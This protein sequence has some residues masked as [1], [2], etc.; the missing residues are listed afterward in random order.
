MDEETIARLVAEAQGGDSEAFGGIFD[1][2][3]EAV[4]RFIASRV[5]SPSDAE[6]LT[7]LVYVKALE[8]LPRYEARGIPFGGWLFRLARNAVID[9]VRTRRDHAELDAATDRPTEERTPETLAILRSDL[10]AMAEALHTLTPDQRE[11]ISLR[12]FAGLSPREA[13]EL[14]GRQEGTIR[15]LQ[16]RAIAAL[17]QR[18]G[19]RSDDH[20]Q[21]G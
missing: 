7:Q 8:A 20:K 4:Y 21:T 5:G 10:D 6:D 16:F 12:F 15:G 18:L 9:H 3:H 17:R 14:M 1:A 19:I 13:A 2:T 11:V